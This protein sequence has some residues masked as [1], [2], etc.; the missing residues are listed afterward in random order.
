VPPIPILRWTASLLTIWTA[1]CVPSQPTD[2]APKDDATPSKSADA[3][4]QAKPSSRPPLK[5][6]P[7][8]VITSTFEDRFDRSSIGEDWYR[9]GNAWSLRNG[10]L[11]AKGA[12]NRG[13][14]LRHRLPTNAR[15][16]FEATSDS[17]DGDIKAE[18]WGDGSS[19][20]TAAS[21]T[22]ATS[23]LTIF[24][25]WKNSF[26]V[27][28]RID[29]HDPN[30]LE[31]PTNAESTIARERPVTPGQ[32]YRFRVER[33]NGKTV[34]WWV[35]DTLIHALEDPDPLVGDGHEH[36]GFNNWD[37]SVCFDNLTITPL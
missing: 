11:C 28:A 15:I 26:H 8:Q 2:A 17:P 10:K 19:G 14:W 16:E 33:T 7:G 36:F 31:L 21:Y 30:R 1:S 18:F 37:V 27:L 25:G 32:V 3:K 13:I 5:P 34:S 35:D 23:Y 24:G 9:V 20:A 12:R 22:N 6:V 4:P 29:E